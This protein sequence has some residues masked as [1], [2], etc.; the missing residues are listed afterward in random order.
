M[1]IPKEQ[2]YVIKELA[3][4]IKVVSE[5]YGKETTGDDYKDRWQL[6]VKL[7]EIR[8]LAYVL[9]QTLDTVEV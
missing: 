9:E 4:N 6:V 2:L 1:S 8:N 3:A 5:G 7:E